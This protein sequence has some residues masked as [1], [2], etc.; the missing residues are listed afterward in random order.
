VI[1]GQ[2][3]D[4]AGEPIL[5]ATVAAWRIEFPQPGIRWLQLIK[6]VRTDDRG[7]Y[8]LHGLMPGQYQIAASRRPQ[9][10]DLLTP[11][12]ELD[13]RL[14]AER[15]GVVHPGPG[16]P[17]FSDVITAGAAAGGE[18]AGMNLTVV[19]PRYVR[20]SGTILDAASRP[21]L[22]GRVEIRPVHIGAGTS[23][24]YY[25]QVATQAGRFTFTNVPAAEYRVSAA[26]SRS[27]SRPEQSVMGMTES[28]TAS[29]DVREDISGFIVQATPPNMLFVSGRVFIDGAPAD[30][31][32]RLRLFAVAAGIPSVAAPFM[33]EGFPGQTVNV[34]K[35]GNF[36]AITGAGF[37]VLLRSTDS[38]SLKSVTADGV[39]VTDGFELKQAITVDV[40][41]ASQ[42][43][44]LE[45]IV[46]PSDGVIA[47]DCDVVV[48]AAEPTHWRTP[49]SRRV[50]TVRCDD[51]GKFRVT[52]LPTGQYLAAISADFDRR[53]WADPDRLERLRAFATP[54][55]V[56]EG[57]TTEVRIEVKR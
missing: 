35:T 45:G 25:S 14:A 2:V 30:A 13:A 47:G 15:A 3:A 52:G 38:G 11:A 56:T 48:F 5:D 44:V 29:I 24:R 6:E 42:V 53:M 10:A 39:D 57:A 33:G 7:A 4:D 51:K 16:L 22:A 43:S 1:S 28:A 19:R 54:F 49:L 8:R 9:S 18:T 20:V 50:V 26:F 36:R 17:T 37:F 31:P 23:G 34:D 21:V 55:T 27:D 46:Q 32:M 12:Q 41:L 40:H